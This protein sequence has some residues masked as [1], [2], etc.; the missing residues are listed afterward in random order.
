[1]ADAD[2]TGS[3]DVVAELLAIPPERF[4]EA[5]NA[6]SKQLREEG[7]RDVADAIKRLPRP[8]LSLWALNALAREQPKPVKAFCDAAAALREAYRS[9]GDI[10]AATA[11]ERAAES[12]LAAAAAERLRAE[13]KNATDTVM[14]SLGQTLRAAAADAEIE[15]ALRKG[16]LLREPEAPSIDDLLGSL[17]A[18]PAAPASAG[19]KAKAAR[20]R[21]DGKERRELEEQVTAAKAKAAEARSEA[22]AT[23][24]AARTAEAEWKRAEKRAGT[25]R[26]RSESAQQRLEQLQQRLA[27]R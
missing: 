8:P 7:R 15:A 24:D 10:R 4:T 3:E 18:A 27:E 25:A 5:R 9:G 19:G 16:L 17:P 11:P 1:M 26:E 21:A 22:R 13:G 20:Q 12:R 2:I 6:T 14:R 23:A